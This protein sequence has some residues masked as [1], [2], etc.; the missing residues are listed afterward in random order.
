MAALLVTLA[1]MAILWT[2]AVPAWRHLMQRDREEELIFRGRQYAR[3]IMLFQRK[4]AN[5]FP[6]NLDVLINQKFLRRKYADPVA[7]GEDKTF[8]ILYQTSQT[9][10][11]GQGGQGQTP[12]P[13]QVGGDAPPQP[14]PGAGQGGGV[15]GGV[16]GVA[17]KSRE[18]SIR[19]YNGRSRYNEW[20]FLATEAT[21][22]PG[23]V[24][25]AGPA[26]GKPGVPTPGRP[27]GP[28]PQ[29][30]SPVPGRP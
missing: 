26:T 5:A 8:Q 2:M 27:G 22:R 21:Q 4:Y 16:I 20:Q 13:G 15:A 25:G 12:R 30:R 10:A 19:V 11:P 7:K 24:P 14:A 29:P 1:I 6:P 18:K 17:S 3:G 23:V 9:G 28:V